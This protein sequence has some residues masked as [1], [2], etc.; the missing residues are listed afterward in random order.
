M[1]LTVKGAASYIQK[2]KENPKKYYKLVPTDH[3]YVPPKK[4]SLPDNF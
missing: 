3:E 2:A 4:K 1:F